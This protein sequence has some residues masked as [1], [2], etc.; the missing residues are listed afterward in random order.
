[1]CPIVLLCLTCATRHQRSRVQFPAD[2]AGELFRA[3]LSVRTD[4]VGCPLHPRVTAATRQTLCPESQCAQSVGCPL[5]PH[6]CSNTTDVVSRVSVCPECWVSAPSPCYCSNTTDVVSRVSVCPECWVSAPSPLLQQHDRR[7]VQSLS[8]PRVLG[9]RSI[10]ITAATRQTLCPE[11]QCAQSVGCPLHPHY[12]S[13]TTDVVSR[14]SVCPE[15]WVSA[16]SPLLQ[17]HDRR[18]VQSLSVPRVLGVR[19]IPV[20][21]QQHDRLRALCP[22]CGWPVAIELTNTFDPMKSG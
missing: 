4:P 5:H 1:M 22:E 3:E 19:S 18:C 20:L 17:Q 8:V 21:L 2:A 6:Y 12:C 15:C 14:V 9:V 7:C 10:P 11:S 13:N 16:P